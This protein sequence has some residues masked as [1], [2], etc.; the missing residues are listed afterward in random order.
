M[1]RRQFLKAAGLA[2][3]AAVVAAPAIAQG[4]AVKWKLTSAFPASLDLLAGGATSF[5]DAA[6]EASG[7]R[8]DIEAHPPGEIAGAV[9]ALD[10][11]KDGK[12]DCALTALSYWWG[13]EPALVF[14]TGAPFGMN[15]R[16]HAAWLDRGG[17]DLVDEV[18]SGHNLVA[19]L[20]GNTGCQMG[21]WFRNDVKSAADFTGMKIRV[22]GIAGRILQKLGA[23]PTAM[24]RDGIAAALKSGALD[25][26]AWVSPADDEKLELAK[27][28]PNY[29]YP[30][31][32]QPSMAVHVAV[33]ADKWKALSNADRAAL[34]QAAAVANA[35]MLAAYDTM[36]PPAVR[37]LVEAG[38]RLKPFPNDAM[39]ALWKAA[40]EVYQEIGDENPAFK[41]LHDSYMNARNEQYLWWQVAEY[42]FD[43][44]IIRQ[45]AKG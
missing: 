18:L 21:G 1:K 3:P 20:A 30:G 9:D 12:A 19:L 5:A 7:G 25:A 4:A 40:G 37:R 39:E 22:A 23:V 29:F 10:A 45:R 44:F 35:S 42:P 14:A 15:S 26:A 38:A 2:A 16:E 11:V 17:N 41:R 13:V 28:A 27:T 32:H 8:V 31:W 36:N 6:R 43:N 24:S 33:N 34:R